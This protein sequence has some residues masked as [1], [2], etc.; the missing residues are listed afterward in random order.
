MLGKIVAMIPGTQIPIYEATEETLADWARHDAE[1]EYQ[2]H[3][4]NPKHAIRLYPPP[5]GATFTQC[6]PLDSTKKAKRRS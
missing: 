6:P 5:V 3:M 2:R 4:R 1:A